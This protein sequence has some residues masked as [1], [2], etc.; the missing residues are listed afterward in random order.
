V[1]RRGPIPCRGGFVWGGEKEVEERREKL[2]AKGRGRPG[3]SPGVEVDIH[4]V[5]SE[6]YLVVVSACL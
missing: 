3:C 5:G 2:Q 4:Y 1:R 6:G